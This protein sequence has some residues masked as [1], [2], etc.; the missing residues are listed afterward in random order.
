MFSW[1]LI[2]IFSHFVS[3]LHWYHYFTKTSNWTWYEWLKTMINL[4]LSCSD[5]Y[6]SSLMLFNSWKISCTTFVITFWMLI[7]S[8]I[9]NLVKMF[10]SIHSHS[11]RNTTILDINWKFNENS[12]LKNIC[13]LNLSPDAEQN[14]LYK[15]AL[16]KLLGNS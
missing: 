3:W 4:D 14:N 15:K 7:R 1:T 9:S 12:Q 8:W 11:K 10:R 6:S 5:A 16:D 2:K 13:V